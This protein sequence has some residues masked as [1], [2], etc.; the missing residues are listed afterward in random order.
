MPIKQAVFKVA[1]L[2]ISLIFVGAFLGQAEERSME[3][4][5]S[6]LS[7]LVENEIAS[8]TG[9][10]FWS[11]SNGM[12]A[13]EL[14]SDGKLVGAKESKTMFSKGDVVY[15]L[16]DKE[17]PVSSNE[18][19]LF[20]KVKKVYHPKTGEFMGDLIEIT[21]MV[22]TIENHEQ[23]M[24]GQIIHSREA[25]SLNDEL[26]AIGTLLRTATPSA[27]SP[28]DKK[29]GTIIEVRDDRLNIG[30]QDI[31]YIDRGRND[32][33]VPGHQFEI[34]HDGQ[35]SSR[36]TLPKR[37]AGRLV[38]LSTQEQTSTARITESSEPISKGDPLQFLPKN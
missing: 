34:L 5:K 32:G 18:W 22:K 16:L 26:I 20:R 38:V 8:S 14:K 28:L 2:T 4:P 33:I 37:S 9:N 19:V 31:V 12:I 25:I 36:T 29:E 6:S 7:E 13:R 21:G 1:M 30:E 24:T 17:A 35:K 27:V 11:L 23:N 15:L 10:D 3:E